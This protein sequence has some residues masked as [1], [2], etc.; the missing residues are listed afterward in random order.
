MQLTL[1][2]N[3]F[4]P[5]ARYRRAKLGIVSRG[6]RAF[7]EILPAG[8]GILD[9]I[10]VTFVGFM[11][12]RIMVGTGPA[13]AA[14]YD[15]FVSAAS[16]SLPPKAENSTSKVHSQHNPRAPSSHIIK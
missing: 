2:D 10:V 16:T 12:Q 14:I 11:R 4:M 15:N 8:L 13:T 3:P 6:R 5:L 7:L 9:L 1:G